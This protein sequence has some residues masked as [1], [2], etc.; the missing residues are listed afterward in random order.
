MEP[1]SMTAKRLAL[2]CDDHM[3]RIET[4]ASKVRPFLG[5]EWEVQVATGTRLVAIVEALSQAE[6]PWR[7]AA[8]EKATLD[9][10]TLRNGIIGRDKEMLD[11]LD[12]AELIIL[13]SDLT[14]NS[15]DITTLGEDGDAVN[16]ALRNQSGET[17][18]RQLRSFTTAGYLI[19][20]N[21][22]YGDRFFDLTM[23]KWN[24]GFADLY[25]TN[26][27]VG[28]AALWTGLPEEGTFNPWSWPILLERLDALPHA[29][30]Y[31]AD[32]L[33]SNVFQ[34]LE[35]DADDLAPEQLD[36]F[37]HLDAPEAATFED[38]AW[39]SLGF[40]FLVEGATKEQITR[41]AASVLLR[42][43]A[44][45]VVA[46]QNVVLDVPHILARH[47]RAFGAGAADQEFWTS[48]AAKTEAPFAAV[49]MLK[50]ALSPVGELIG[51]AVYSAELVRELSSQLPPPSVAALPLVFAEDVSAFFE[52]DAV[53]QFTSKLPGTYFR[54]FI[55]APEEEEVDYRPSVRR[56]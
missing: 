21:R 32:D 30:S 20:V 56:R 26:T 23:S 3:T 48:M 52:R 42:W 10:S 54:R 27:D 4:W 28:D 40:R 45:S 39:S 22:F 19:V 12:R 53:Q 55:R 18:A 13:D 1:K 14:P 51:R 41:M 7:E 34:K 9:A 44:R 15:G 16:R 47:P 6:R 36:A 24:N 38:L 33:Q 37:A 31:V 8:A 43:L 25:I 46:P 29:I 11:L 49:A 5:D 2:I 50:P 35:L 17:L